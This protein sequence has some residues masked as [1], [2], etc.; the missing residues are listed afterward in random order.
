MSRSGPPKVCLDLTANEIHD[1]HGGIG[2]YGYYLAEA[3]HQLQPND[4][5]IVALRHS[6]GPVVS[7]EEAL[8]DRGLEEPILDSATYRTRRYQMSGP[9]MERAG[10]QLF[11]ATQPAALPRVGKSIRL[12]STVHDLI[13]LAYPA[14]GS[15]LIGRR[16]QYWRNLRRWRRRTRPADAILAISELTR[17]DI[18]RLLKVAAER[19]A[20]VAHGVDTA[21]FS[22]TGDCDLSRFRL[23]KRGFVSVGSDHYRK[24]QR[25]LLE[26]WLSCA[27]EIEEGLVLVG[28][29]LYDSTL[30]KLFRTV[31]ERGLEERVLW[32]DDVSDDEL[33]GLY[34][35]ARAAF[36][37]SLY[38]G[39]GM[40]SLEAMACGT[41]V[42]AARGGAY[43]EV[44]Q[45]AALYYD[46]LS[47]C[48][49]AETM[50]KLSKDDALVK[51]YTQRGLERI[52]SFTW[53]Q[54]AEGTLDLY[55]RVLAGG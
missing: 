40:T 9:V 24:N 5:E 31:Q 1:R 19:L 47:V 43:E 23:T 46:G 11:H 32:L 55:R 27:D 18:V 30:Q 22:P 21:R 48:E 15:H 14:P 17:R 44:A 29:A 26:A 6:A 37:P 45:E 50:L 54:C 3:L 4:L 41:P 8:K 42:A 53:R 35:W 13:P 39:F 7:L 10:V 25:R 51:D 28:R 33:P 49:M 34:R 38:E 36:C 20:V 2:K 52:R 16:L 12:V